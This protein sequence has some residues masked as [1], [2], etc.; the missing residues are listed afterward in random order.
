MFKWLAIAAFIAL[1]LIVVAVLS[2]AVAS[3]AFG[4]FLAWLTNWQRRE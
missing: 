4:R 2:I 3:V 1:L